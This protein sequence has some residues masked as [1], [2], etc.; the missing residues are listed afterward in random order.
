[1][2]RKGQ[3]Y[4]CLWHDMMMMMMSLRFLLFFTSLFPF[5]SSIM[6]CRYSNFSVTVVFFQYSFLLY[7]CTV[8]FINSV[9]SWCFF[10]CCFTFHILV[11]ISSVLNG[12]MDGD[13]PVEFGMLVN[14]CIAIVTFFIMYFTYF[15]ADSAIPFEFGISGELGFHLNPYLIANHSLFGCQIQGPHYLQLLLECHIS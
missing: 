10:C 14:S 12:D 6:Y 5:S 9:R 13:I 1:M 11:F 8:P 3:G 15:I 4:P 7:G 2:A